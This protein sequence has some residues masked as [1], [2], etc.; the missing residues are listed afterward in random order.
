M[1][2]AAT[3]GAT[4]F[5]AVTMTAT[6]TAVPAHAQSAPSASDLPAIDVKVNK[7]KPKRKRP[8]PRPEQQPQAEAANRTQR[9]SPGTGQR[10]QRPRQRKSGNAVRQ[11]PA[12]V[13]PGGRSRRPDR[14]RRRTPDRLQADPVFNISDLVK[15]VPGVS[16]KQGNG[17][18]DM[19]VS[20]RGSGARTGFGVRNIVL[21]EDGFP[22]TQPDG[23]GRTDLIDPHAYSG[24]DVWRGP[25]S[26]LFGNYATGGA[27]NF[28]TRP[29]GEID[30][31]EYGHRCGQLRL[32]Q[33]LR[34]GGRQIRKRRGGDLR[35]RRARRRLL[36]LQ[37]LRHSDGQRPGEL[38]GDARRQG[39]V[40][41]HRQR[42]LH[43]TSV[44]HVAERVSRTNPFQK[45]CETA[46]TA[47]AGCDKIY[48]S[49]TGNT[50][51]DS[52]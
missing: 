30:G 19:T 25:S 32:S 2:G 23:L 38:P 1:A 29:G 44:P 27:I 3:I 52:N 13:R 20:I 43:R 28:R 50:G 14:D 34:H 48:L 7:P 33:Q 16:L 46:A 21:F 45:G 41:V 47:A 42:I 51:K 36:R 4:T 26:A 15:D 6:M 22:V 17:P 40:Q 35:Q 5:A 12:H 49:R 8:A 31:V 39:H 9:D 24:V 37:R 11:R 10:Q 18:R